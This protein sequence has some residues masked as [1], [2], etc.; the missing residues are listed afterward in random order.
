MA[1]QQNWGDRLKAVARF[2]RDFTQFVAAFIAILLAGGGAI[3][4][5]FFK[6]QNFFEE[7][8]AFAAGA[9][10]TALI[11]S[12]I[13][14]WA[15]ASIST[16]WLLRGYKLIAAEYFY[17]IHDE[18]KVH[19]SQKTTIRLKALH[20]GVEILELRYKW[21]GQ[22][23]EEEPQIESKDLGH[24]L[25][26]SAEPSRVGDWQYYYIHFGRPL[27]ARDEIVVKVKQDF[28]DDNL[29]F[30]PRLSKT[31]SEPLE[32]LTLRVKIPGRLSPKNIIFTEL[33]SNQANA[34]IIY[35]EAYSFDAT[36][37]E[38]LW[39]PKKLR[40]GHKY[41]ITWDYDPRRQQLQSRNQRSSQQSVSRRSQ[42]KRGH[43][44]VE[45]DKQEPG[46]G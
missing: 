22:G 20:Y 30:S 1:G 25:I 45:T 33:D 24:R 37:K 36:T 31:I 4:A 7:L 27:H 17:E 29:R 26:G 13:Y 28:Y 46:K 42:N 15:A 19:H 14:V 10:I 2:I 44:P 6:Q 5:F 32:K 8:I 18:N 41:V 9:V 21:T 3:A 34:Q 35:Q 43:T 39:E 40:L 23:R 12:G 16:K 11:G 38:I